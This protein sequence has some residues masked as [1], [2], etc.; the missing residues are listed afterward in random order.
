MASPIVFAYEFT[1]R[2]SIDAAWREVSDTDR[3]NRAIGTGFH[4]TRTPDGRTRGSFSK[5]G[6]EI[7]WEEQPFSYRAP[8]WFRI[9]RAFE[10]GPAE[11]VVARC[12]LTPLRGEDGVERGTHIVYRVEATPRGLLSSAL[13]RV[14]FQTGIK[15]RIGRALAEIVAALD[16]GASLD[17][18][19]GP[20]PQL[21]PSGEEHL[22]RAIRKLT[23]STAVDR[24]AAFLRAGP[25]RDQARMSPQLLAQAWNEQLDDTLILLFRAVEAGLLAVRL[26]LLCPACLVPRQVFT[27]EATRVHCEAC[28]IEYDANFPENLAVHFRPSPQI[29]SFE[30][31]VDCIGS[32]GERRH[33]VAQERLGPGQECDLVTDFKAGMHRVRTLPAYGPPAILE[34]LDGGGARDIAFRCGSMVH[35]Q[36][37]RI[38]APKAIPF[39]NET[40]APLVVVVERLERPPQIVTAG[41]LVAEFPQFR[42][43][44]PVLPFFSGVELYR[45]VALAV[46]FAEGVDIS[47]VSLARARVTYTA[48]RCVLAVYAS[49]REALEDLKS[50][51]LLQG[52]SDVRAFAGLA[53][54]TTFEQ[55]RGTQRVPMGTSVDDAYAAMG[56][57]GMGVVTCVASYAATRDAARDLEVAS[58]GVSPYP[59]RAATGDALVRLDG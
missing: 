36:Y 13:L 41:R 57:S 53:F 55:T 45:A 42:N 4:F 19:G 26:D 44:A 38:S 3:F 25:L 10:S 50:L 52:R 31:P 17:N 33:I 28:N 21:T 16:D 15:P 1:T 9:E 7:R 59:L 35:P 43:L 27:G 46:T 48:E 20:P 24:L 23:P 5:L 37:A 39:R 54:G 51:G 49:L 14:D 32:P 8:R 56:A 22:R 2:A 11:R 12:D 47:L 6:L 29:R 40:S 58:V 30:V 34:M 18:L